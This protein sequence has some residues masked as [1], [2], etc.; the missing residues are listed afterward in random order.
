MTSFPLSLY[1]RHPFHND[2]PLHPPLL[3]QDVF[4]FIEAI[5]PPENSQ[6]TKLTSRSKQ[7]TNIRS[8]GLHCRGNIIFSFLVQ[9]GSQFP[10]KPPFIT[11]EK[12]RQAGGG[13][14]STQSELITS[15]AIPSHRANNSFY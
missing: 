7:T 5:F 1:F 6:A 13:K 14:N 3:I 2:H 11:T 10:A 9:Y 4:A 8:L 15:R 12:S